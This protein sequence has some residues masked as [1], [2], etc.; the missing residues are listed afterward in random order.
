MPK[1]DAY[2]KHYC[3]WRNHGGAKNQPDPDS[4]QYAEAL[5]REIERLVYPSIH[6]AVGFV[7]NDAKIVYSKFIEWFM[8]RELNKTETLKH[9][10]QLIPTLTLPAKGKFYDSQVKIWG[11]NV[12]E[13]MDHTENFGSEQRFGPTAGSYEA[14]AEILNKQ[15]ESLKGRGYTLLN[16]L[17]QDK[18]VLDEEEAFEYDDETL[19]ETDLF[20]DD[21]A[22][23]DAADSPEQQRIDALLRELKKLL[24]KKV[25]SEKLADDRVG[26]QGGAKFA[27]NVG[28]VI[29]K[30]GDIRIPGAGFLRWK[31]PLIVKDWWQQQ[32]RENKKQQPK[33]PQGDDGEQPGGNLETVIASGTRQ[34]DP[35]IKTQQEIDERTS[36]KLVERLLAEPLEA[37]QATRE[38]A[39]QDYAKHLAAEEKAMAALDDSV[40]EQTPHSQ[41][42]AKTI[43][44]TQKAAKEVEKAEQRVA[45]KASQYYDWMAIYTLATDGMK[46]MDIARTLFMPKDSNFN[47]TPAN[48]EAK[49]AALKKAEDDAWQKFRDRQDE[50]KKILAPLYETS[51]QQVRLND[52][53]RFLS[54]PRANGAGL[55]EQITDECWLRLL[56]QI[57]RI[58]KK[59]L[60][61]TEAELGKWEQKKRTAATQLL[62]KFEDTGDPIA[63]Q[64]QRAKLLQQAITLAIPD[65]STLKG[66]RLTE[67]QVQQLRKPW[68]TAQSK[69]QALEPVLARQ[70]A[71]YERQKQQCKDTLFLLMTSTEASATE[72]GLRL[73]LGRSKD[74]ADPDPE[75]AKAQVTERRQQIKDALASLTD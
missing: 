68:L 31:A 1:T 69:I 19:Q 22:D 27:L 14:Q 21:E 18:D 62:M 39:K 24:A 64:A 7:E 66:L 53:A 65:A 54:M 61:E 48:D 56:G 6:F 26:L 57:N 47:V 38:A 36:L 17:G 50:L 49:Q 41:A 34:D 43:Y 33:S 35:W 46:Q 58:L 73:G 74:S 75:K 70:Q 13:W 4:D 40:I 11:G 30:S 10:Q 3:R 63:D 51:T 72:T 9:F 15:Q 55:G 37:A 45:R 2:L 67:K 12:L 32:A 52:S 16:W 42:V 25:A 23:L 44:R 60:H 20:D 71:E 28:E 59:P 29:H 8:E 5:Y